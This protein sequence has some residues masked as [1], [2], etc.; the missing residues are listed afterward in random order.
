MVPGNVDLGPE[1]KQMLERTQ[2]STPLVSFVIPEDKSGTT[3]V[4]K[5]KRSPPPTNIDRHIEAEGKVQSER[6]EDALQETTTA[7]ASTE[8][9]PSAVDSGK[10]VGENVTVAPVG[11]EYVSMAPLVLVNRTEETHPPPSGMPITS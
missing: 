8:E 6:I 7:E 11:A 2:R 1:P 9:A 3:P 4:P 5:P 10:L